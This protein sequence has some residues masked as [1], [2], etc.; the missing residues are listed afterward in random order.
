[1]FTTY[2]PSSAKLRVL[3]LSSQVKSSQK[4]FIQVN[5]QSYHTTLK[6]GNPFGLMCPYVWCIYTRYVI[7]SSLTSVINNNTG[8]S[9]RVHFNMVVLF[10]DSLDFHSAFKVRWN[11]YVRS[12]WIPC[13]TWFINRHSLNELGD[14]SYTRYNGI[15]GLTFQSNGCEIAAWTRVQIEHF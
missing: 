6:D 2:I 15:K 14:N 5:T 7:T 1:M 4:Y 12:K 10:I 13:N 3:Q 11:R 9:R 8:V